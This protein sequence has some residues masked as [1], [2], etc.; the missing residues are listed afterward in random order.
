MQHD[1]VVDFVAE[2]VRVFGDEMRQS[3][4]QDRRAWVDVL[5]RLGNG[6]EAASVVASAVRDAFTR[7]SVPVTVVQPPLSQTVEIDTSAIAASVQ[8]MSD[9]V[10]AALKAMADTAQVYAS[11]PE[12][13]PPLLPTPQ[14]HVSVDTAPIAKAF[15]DGESSAQTSLVQALVKHA[16]SVSEQA[17]ALEKLAVVLSRPKKTAVSVERNSSGEIVKFNIESK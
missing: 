2:T 11:K 9:A 7:L 16:D 5:D 3:L 6:Q 4:A 12:P 13:I 14:V 15:A 8:P 17:R 1:D 10:L